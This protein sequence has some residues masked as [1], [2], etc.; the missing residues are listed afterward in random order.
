[1]GGKVQPWANGN[2]Q[3]ALERLDQPTVLYQEGEHAIYW[4]GIAEARAFRGNVY[5]LRDGDCGILIDP[6]SRSHFLQ[7]RNR[8]AQIMPPES[9]TGMVICHQDPDVAAA[10][11]DWLELKPSLSVFTSP[12]TNELLP[13]YGVDH[14]DFYDVEAQPEYMLPSGNKLRFIPAPFLH[15]SGAIT[16]YDSASGGL[17]TGDIWGAIDMD[18]QLL[19]S[20]FDSHVAKMNLFHTEYMAS[21]L[22]ARGFLHRIEGLHIEAIL[23]QHGSVIGPQYVARA[24]EYLFNLR[25]GT[26]IIYA[27]I[28]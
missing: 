6:G 5:L 18:W 13:Y 27:G 1:L 17:F 23:P 14:Y 11:V 26:D 19:V 15:F 10:M 22:A 2:L 24:R 16:T 12:R 28:E 21:N 8:V 20:D 3:G 9:L 7:I 25:C 4:L